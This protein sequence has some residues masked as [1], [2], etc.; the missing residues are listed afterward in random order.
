MPGAAHSPAS[1]ATF[2]AFAAEASQR[3]DVRAAAVL[4]AP[5]GSA[6]SGM[7]PA[8]DG[9]GSNGGKGAPEPKPS[10]T[11]AAAA[12]TA[13][14]AA[15]AA[16]AMGGADAVKQGSPGSAGKGSAGKSKV[17]RSAGKG[18][19]VGQALDSMQWLTGTACRLEWPAQHC[20]DVGCFAVLL[21]CAVQ[22]CAPGGVEKAGPACDPRSQKMVCEQG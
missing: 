20:A 1:A 13:A 22:C 3:D 6:R 15:A 18:A 17:A 7:L 10:A 4:A 14:A 5:S 2:A 21:C 11:A 12:F 19:R 8:A 9:A 16:A